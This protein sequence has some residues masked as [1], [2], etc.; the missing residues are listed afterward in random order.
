MLHVSKVF[1]HSPSTTGCAQSIMQLLFLVVAF[2]AAVFTSV[3]I[4][5][6]LESIL[7][8][9]EPTTQPAHKSV[10]PLPPPDMKLNPSRI[11]FYSDS[12]IYAV[13]HTPHILAGTTTFSVVA[14]H[15]YGCKVPA[16][17]DPQTEAAS[18]EVILVWL[19]LFKWFGLRGC[20]FRPEFDF[21][22]AFYVVYPFEFWGLGFLIRIE[23]GVELTTGE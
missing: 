13:T 20:E 12:A 6:S 5:K 14:S 17:T 2:L 10:T 19:P 7:L 21:E 15:I 23:S 9:L 3:L 22:Q 1:E 16:R 11:L 18:E 4:L 8:S